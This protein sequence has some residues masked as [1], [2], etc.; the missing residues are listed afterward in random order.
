MV[1]NLKNLPFQNQESFEAESWNIALWT[2]GVYKDFC[3]NDDRNLTFDLFAKGQN[4]VFIRFYGKI[5]KSRF[6]KMYE[7]NG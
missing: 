3:S 4:C 7:T 5:L 2:Q 1:K 6:L